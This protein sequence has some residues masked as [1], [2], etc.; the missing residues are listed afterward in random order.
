MMMM[1]MM[2]T[3]VVGV[4]RMLRRLSFWHVIGRLRL[5]M[6]AVCTDFMYSFVFLFVD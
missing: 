1:M 4:I 6:Q 3:V 5:F 2:M